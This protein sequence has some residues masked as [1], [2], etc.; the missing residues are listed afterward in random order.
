MQTRHLIRSLATDSARGSVPTWGLM[1][2]LV[3]TT[4]LNLAGMIFFLGLR[5][6][7]TTALTGPPLVK[8]LLPL[9]L[10]WLALMLAMRRAR[11]AAP[12]GGLDRALIGLIALVGLTLAGGILRQGGATLA[13][14]LAEGSMVR[15]IIS[16]PLLAIAPLAVVLWALSAGAPLAPVWAGALAGLGAGSLATAVYSLSCPDDAAQFFVPV[17][18][19]A[20]ALVTGAGAALGDRLL[21]W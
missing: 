6:D 13:A 5:P 18:G 21:R 15:A 19:F 10:A 17:Y 16:I 7:L 3:F 2:A 20:I 8:T 1:G 9:L 11:P 4:V 14:T 12:S